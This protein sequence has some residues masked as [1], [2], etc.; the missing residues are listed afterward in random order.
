MS[1]ISCDQ[2]QEF[3][4]YCARIQTANQPRNGYRSLHEFILAHG[5]SYK[6]TP[7]PAEHV[8]GPARECFRNAALLALREELIYVEG[9]AAGVIPLEHAWCVDK[10]DKVYEVTWE[11]PGTSYFGIPFKTSYLMS[12]LRKAKVYGI[13]GMRSTIEL[14]QTPPEKWKH[15]IP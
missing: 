11:E 2:V 3:L 13:F 4:K 5:Q 10:E 8:R 9:Y 12:H 7:L 1:A 15:S 14:I 6:P